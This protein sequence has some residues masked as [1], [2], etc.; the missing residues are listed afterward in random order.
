MPI[1]ATGLD[2]FLEAQAPVWAQVVRELTAGRKATHWM[3]FVFPQLKGLG[4]TSTAQFYGIASRAEA[5]A[6]WQHPALGLRL[7]ECAELVLAAP[8]GLTAQNV[9]GS[10]DDMKLRSS[11]TLFAAVAPEESVFN[12]VLQRFYGGEPDP[13]T[14]AMLR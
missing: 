9:L 7:K 11:M 12:G 10:P 3:W 2:R 1:D 4:R 8:S 5:L 14:L 13:V 6:Y